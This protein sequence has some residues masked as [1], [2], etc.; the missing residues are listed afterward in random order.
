MWTSWIVECLQE[1]RAAG[2]D[3]TARQ[4]GVEPVGV[5]ELNS[6]EKLSLR[7]VDSILD[8]SLEYLRRIA[9]DYLEGI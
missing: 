1:L 5:V 2:V 6:P 8:R 4:M 7:S 9:S 3:Q